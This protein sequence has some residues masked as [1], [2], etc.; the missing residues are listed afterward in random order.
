MLVNFEIAVNFDSILH[1][2]FLQR[3]V[4]FVVESLDRFGLLGYYG[5]IKILQFFFRVILKK[6]STLI[7]N[8]CE[9]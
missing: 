9:K 6:S 5:N 7:S 8:G 1:F 3:V 4:M 2:I